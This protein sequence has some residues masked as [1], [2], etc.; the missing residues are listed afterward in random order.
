MRLEEM[1]MRRKRFLAFCTACTLLAAYGVANAAAVGE[2]ETPRDAST[3][4]L[5]AD[6]LSPY[7]TGE[8]LVARED[9]S[10][11]VLTFDIGELVSG[12]EKPAQNEDITGFY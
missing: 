12:L 5:V 1:D 2:S 8:V 7:E 10:L 9:G 11:E 4:V 6:D 3:G